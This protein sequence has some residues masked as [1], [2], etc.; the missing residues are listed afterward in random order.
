MENYPKT[1]AEWESLNSKF[2]DW[3]YWNYN[4]LETKS[5][6][7]DNKYLL[8]F[9]N[10][11]IKNRNFNP[12][13]AIQENYSFL[14]SY[15]LANYKNDNQFKGKTKTEYTLEALKEETKNI[16]SS[17]K[18]GLNF[19][20]DFLKDLKVYLPFFIGLGFLYYYN[21]LK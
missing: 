6:P 18:E 16:Y 19:G 9:Y 7:L 12:N 5:L 14:F 10:T 3:Y 8:D 17:A 20:I 4:N 1:Q 21:K 11:D 2:Y 13:P 15:F